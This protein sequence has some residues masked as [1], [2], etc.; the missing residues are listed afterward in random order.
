MGEANIESTG[1]ETQPTPVVIRKSRFFIRAKT[2]WNLRFKVMQDLLRE[3]RICRINK[4]HDTGG[5][6]PFHPIPLC[7]RRNWC[8]RRLVLEVGNPAGTAF[9]QMGFAQRFKIATLC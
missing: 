2:N 4:D 7:V 8:L 5:A 6:H 9:H 1:G 3:I